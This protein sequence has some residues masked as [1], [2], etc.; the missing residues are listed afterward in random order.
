MRAL[1]KKS[2]KDNWNLFDYDQTHILNIVAVYKL[3]SNFNISLSLR[4]NTGNPYTPIVGSVLDSDKNSYIP[5]YADKNSKRLKNFFQVDF[6]IN[7]DF[8]FEYWKLSLY[9]DIQNVT[10][11]KNEEGKMYNYNYTDFKIV[12][13]IPFFPSIGIKGSF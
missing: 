5:I 8:V 3:F 10:N 1:Y 9:M 4:Y 6:K 13:A 7:K 12:E 11:Y 2:D